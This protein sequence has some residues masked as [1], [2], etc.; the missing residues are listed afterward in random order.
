MII[1]LSEISSNFTYQQKNSKYSGTDPIKDKIQKQSFSKTKL[2]KLLR[3]PLKNKFV[4]FS[5]I[6]SLLFNIGIWFLLYL[7]IK[8]KTEPIFL[9]YNIYF[10]IDLI[11][12]WYRIYLIPLSGFVILLVNYLVGAK[13]YQ[14]KQVLT[15]LLVGFTIP[16]QI[17]LGLSAILIIRINI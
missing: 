17:F 5:L 10:G 13:I 12:E 1:H 14:T 8:P 16:L 9:H 15:Y 2:L 11:G 4:S 6:F 7:F 3:E